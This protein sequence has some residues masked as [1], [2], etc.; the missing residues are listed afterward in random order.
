MQV[1]HQLKD[2]ARDFQ[3]MYGQSSGETVDPK[4]MLKMMKQVSSM[5]QTVIGQN[6]T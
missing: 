6:Q 2:A 4:L 1:I 5:V 3:Q